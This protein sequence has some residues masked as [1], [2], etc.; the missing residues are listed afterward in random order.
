MGQSIEAQLNENAG[1]YVELMVGAFS[2][3]QPDYSW[4][5]PYE[6]KTVKQYWY[7]IK[8]I[9]GFKYANLNGAVNLESREDDSVFLGYYSTQLVPKARI[10]LK[11]KEEII[12]EEEVTI[13]PEKAFTQTISVAENF[14]LTDVSTSISNAK[15]G[16]VLIE[17]QPV[18]HEYIE[19]LPETVKP[20]KSPKEIDNLEELF[21]VGSRIE[22]FYNPDGIL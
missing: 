11:Y 6:V 1:P 10:V 22:Q 17:Y 7:P 16:E 4:I 14:E 9:D 13:S 20:P 3:N 21:L 5:K 15:T 18:S 8:D 2:D 12:L 19:D